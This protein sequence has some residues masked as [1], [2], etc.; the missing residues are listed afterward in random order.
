MSGAPALNVSRETFERLETYADLL[1]KWNPRINL[2]A[3]ST[4]DD[5]WTRHIV[6]SAQIFELAA[7]PVGHWVDIGTG[8]GFPG[9]VIAIMAIEAETPAKITLI[10]SDARKCAFLRTVLRE[11]GASARVL[12]QRIEKAPPQSAD[13]LSA[14]ALADLS[15]LLG[16]AKLHLAPM[17]TAL[18]HKGASWKKE[19]SDA[20]Q[21]WKFDHHIATSTTEEGPVVLSI[22]GVARV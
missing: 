2:V 8:G 12:T 15:T 17:G 13:V 11:T 4:L 3:K 6:D 14:R 10:E 22:A 16:F 18:F 5:L 7:H 9:L 19:L 20:Q 1:R 21:K